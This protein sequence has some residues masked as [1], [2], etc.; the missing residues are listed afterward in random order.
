[1]NNAT[2]LTNEQI[3]RYAPSVFAGQPHHDRSD[4]YAF[5]PTVE[6]ID[7]MRQA[8][9][10][11]MSACQSRTRIAEKR[12]FTKHL[13]RFRSVNESLTQVGDS[14]LE[15]NLTNSHDG[16]SS[17]LLDLGVFRLACLNGLRVSEGLVGSVRIR[18]I[19]NIVEQVVGAS[20]E[21]LRNADV[22]SGTIK[23]W[24]SI[25]LTEGEQKIF[26]E[27]AFTLR[28]DQDSS[29]ARAINPHQLL[30]VR[31]N[32]DAGSNLWSVFNRVQENIIRGGVRG[33][34]AA[35]FTRIKT[36]PVKGIDQDSKLNKALWSLAT[37]MA[38]IKS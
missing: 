31:R 38:E 25:E 11:P 12:N 17:Y 3:Q 19:G 13:I 29:I 9:F 14:S 20:F 10:Q 22:V 33:Y 26:A 2:P 35:R 24:R 5:V 27:E 6:V 32:A 16:T 23:V 7:G 8:G 36:R 34:D 4:R 1:M 21:L 30:G 18:H 28:F 15:A 37:K